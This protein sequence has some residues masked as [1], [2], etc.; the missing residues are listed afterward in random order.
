MALIVVLSSWSTVHAPSVFVSVIVPCA[1]TDF[2]SRASIAV[3]SSE[4]YW[5]TISCYEGTVP[6]LSADA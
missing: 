2:S 6:V 4:K 3:L 1:V 5:A